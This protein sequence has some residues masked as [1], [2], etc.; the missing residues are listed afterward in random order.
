MW[1]PITQMASAGVAYPF[2]MGKSEVT[3]AEYVEFLNAVAASGPYGLYSTIM[4]SATSGG[5]LVK[6]RGKSFFA[7]SCK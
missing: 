6:V 1:T 3:N 5:K 4:G 2:R 7:K